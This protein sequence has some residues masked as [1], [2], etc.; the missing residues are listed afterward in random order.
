MRLRDGTPR[1]KALFGALV[2]F[3]V[4]SV[5]LGVNDVVRQIGQPRSGVEYVFH[6]LFPGRPDVAQAGLRAGSTLITLNG[7]D[8]ADLTRPQILALERLDRGAV[9]TLQVRDLDGSLVQLTLPVR[10]QTWTDVFY[11]NAVSF[12]MATIF[13]C[14]LVTFAIRPYEPGSWALL[15]FGA[16]ACGGV[17]MMTRLTWQAGTTSHMLA[18]VAYALVAPAILHVGLVFP[19]VH[20]ALHRR[21]LWLGAVYGTGLAP[22]TVAWA[23]R[24]PHTPAELR[25]L[26]LLLYGLQSLYVL[27]F[28]SRLLV[29]LRGRH[30][31]LVR[32]RA[33]I[34]FFA[35]G[36]GVGGN[37]LSSVAALLLPGSIADWRLTWIPLG[38]LPVALAYLT[39]RQDLVDARIA[40][41]RVLVY[42]AAGGVFL[43]LVWGAATVSAVAAAVLLVPFMLVWP[44]VYT[45]V[46]GWLYPK[47]AEFPK[48]SDGSFGLSCSFVSNASGGRGILTAS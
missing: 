5:G 46:N 23:T 44:R 33:W 16:V 43:A 38:V 10:V 34:V 14:M 20:P 1:Q 21:P 40:V 28:I 2:G 9:N 24:M 15:V 25:G 19:T 27:A 18:I 45:R 39:L 36:F 13:F 12:A 37:V 47:R 22:L 7:V 4:L 29:M 31:L 35:L 11:F 32:Q 26:V 48:L 17:S 6:I 30:P 42:V 3:Y 41:R 8:V